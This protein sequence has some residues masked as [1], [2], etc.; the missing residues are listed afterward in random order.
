ML[1]Q[2]IHS[3]FDTCLQLLHQKGAG[4]LQSWCSSCQVSGTLQY[5]S[6]WITCPESIFCSTSDF[7]YYLQQVILATCK[8]VD[9]GSLQSSQALAIFQVKTNTDQLLT[10]GS[11]G[12]KTPL[13][14]LAGR[15]HAF[16]PGYQMGDWGRRVLFV[17]QY[18]L[19]AEAACSFLILHLKNG[20]ET[21]LS[22]R[23]VVWKIR[24]SGGMATRQLPDK[25][26]YGQFSILF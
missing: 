7:L 22:C 20:I 12:K 2:N 10:L 16:Q 17:E 26:F 4:F 1:L 6:V 25:Y 19:S 3:F 18:P 21:L 9:M 8:L 14:C 11:C 5:I 23:G 24:C 13:H 15:C